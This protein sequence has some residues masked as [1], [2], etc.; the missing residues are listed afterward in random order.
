[1]NRGVAKRT[2]FESVADIRYF[3][4]R[5]ARSV[6]R[7][8]IEVHAWCVLTTHFHLLLRSPAGELSDAMRRIQNEYVRRFNIG[9][10]RDG[11]LMRGRF[12]SKPVHSLAYRRTLVRY[13]D[14]NPVRAGL[15]HDAREYP[16]CSAAQYARRTG[17]KW[18]TRTWVEGFVQEAVQAQ[19][20]V[21]QDYARAF[22]SGSPT[23]TE[24]IVERRLMAPGAPRDELDDLLG[25]APPAV[26][27]WMRRKA[28]L[29]DGT[30]PGLPLVDAATLLDQIDWHRAR[31]G[32]LTVG[33]GR[34][35]ADGWKLLRVGLLR[36][37]AGSGFAEI[38]SRIGR[39][40]GQAGRL[41]QRYREAVCCEDAYAAT[42]ASIVE[43]ALL[44]AY[45]PPCAASSVSSIP[46]AS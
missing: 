25:A 8:E 29:A 35:R 31:T 37:C 16:H 7:G 20:Y 33:S 46:R 2:L 22:G 1:M 43:S 3:L 32:A 19:Q 11:P 18:L 24:E 42:A 23:A 15:V 44:V 40:A 10:R 34:A 28:R 30:A 38:A 12:R 4:S 21:P 5:L 13:I 27:A 17:P 36:E 9:R 26:M 41:N 39:T 6:R 45:G 14:A